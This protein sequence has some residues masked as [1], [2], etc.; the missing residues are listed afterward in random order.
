MLKQ[1]KPRNDETSGA[2]SQETIVIKVAREMQDAWAN[3]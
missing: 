3:L 1:D 2:M